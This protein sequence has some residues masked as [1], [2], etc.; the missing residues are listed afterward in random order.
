MYKAFGSSYIMFK[1]RNYILKLKNITAI[2]Y[3]VIV[4]N[5]TILVSQEVTIHL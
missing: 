1:T 3:A 4:D 5:L 2:W